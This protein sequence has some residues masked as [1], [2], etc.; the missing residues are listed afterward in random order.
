MA[1]IRVARTVTGRDLIV[2]FSGA[3]HGIFDEVLVRSAGAGG[4]PRAVPLAPGIPSNMAENILVLEYGSAEALEVIE[5]RGGELAAVL[6]EPVQS[7][8]P[9]LQ[10]RDFVKKLRALTDSSGAALILDEVV[11]GFRAHSGGIHGDDAHGII[12]DRIGQHAGALEIKVS[13]ERIAN[14]GAVVMI[15]G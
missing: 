3:Y 7:R 10:P 6:V 12:F 5:K 13:W 11:S 15:A 1:A 2:M 9:E 14:I 4:T 8:R